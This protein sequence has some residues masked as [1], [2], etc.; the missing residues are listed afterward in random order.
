MQAGISQLTTAFPNYPVTSIPV[1]ESLHLKSFLSMAGPLCVAVGKSAAA[2]EAKKIIEASGKFKYS[3]FE[4]PDDIGA[5]CLYLNGAIV[6]VSEKDYP[7][8]Y[9]LFKENHTLTD[10]KMALSVSEL[11]KVDGC[12]TCCSVLIK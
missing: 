1:K 6:H 3:F 10:K 12:F 9:Q 5:N 7:S 11:N 2:Q 4:L 8:S